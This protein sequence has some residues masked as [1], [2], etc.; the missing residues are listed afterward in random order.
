IQDADARSIEGA[1]LTRT[2][3]SIDWRE[4]LAQ[5]SP[6]RSGTGES[7]VATSGPEGLVEVSLLESGAYPHGSVV[8]ITHPDFL[9]RS[10][11]LAAGEEVSAIPS[12]LILAGAPHVSAHVVGPN[13]EP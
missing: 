10:L 9:A 13:D 3:L 12:T 7:A 4:E 11:I 1:T 5:G 2:A 6:S 8:W